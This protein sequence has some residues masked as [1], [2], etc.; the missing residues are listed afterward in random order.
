MEIFLKASIKKDTELSLLYN[1]L[2]VPQIENTL[3]AKV[4]NFEE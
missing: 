1:S 3:K 2:H 4:G